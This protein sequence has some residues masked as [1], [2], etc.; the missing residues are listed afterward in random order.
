MP[1]PYT[2]IGMED[3]WYDGG[4]DA[5]DEQPVAE[6]CV[7]GDGVLR[8]AGTD[9][10]PENACDACD[11]PVCSDCRRE[12]LCPNCWMEQNPEGFI[13]YQ[14]D[15]RRKRYVV[16]R[17]ETAERYAFKTLKE[18]YAFLDAMGC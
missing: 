8:A 6:C 18:A 5:E 15:H 2:A 4:R 12:G 13:C 3:A 17:A 7:C 10:E 11:E 9:D 1:N 16:E 14:P